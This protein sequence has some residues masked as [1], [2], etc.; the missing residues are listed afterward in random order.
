MKVKKKKDKV[1]FEKIYSEFL[2]NFI[3]EDIELKVENVGRKT[4]EKRDKL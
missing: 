2:R 1:A 4:E 3:N